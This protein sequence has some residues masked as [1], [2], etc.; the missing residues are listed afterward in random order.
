MWLFTKNS[1]VSVVSHRERP[2]DCLVRAR[3]KQHLTRLF[4]EKAKEIFEDADAD[5]RWRLILSKQELADRISGYILQSLDYDNFKAAQ[6]Q[7]DP[8]WS[9][10]LHAVWGEGLR[11][12]K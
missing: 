12:Q 2:N 3:V 10:L 8:A 11:L 5:Y 1:F 7:D 4:P 6:E 9:R